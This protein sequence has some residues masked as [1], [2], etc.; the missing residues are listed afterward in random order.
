[1]WELLK[2]FAHHRPTPRTITAAVRFK[3]FEKI[4]AGAK[5]IQDS[6]YKHLDLKPSNILLRVRP[7]GSWN[8]ID[9]VITDFGI[10][11]QTNKQTGNAGTP[12]FASP[13]QLIGP[14]DRKSDNYSFGRLMTMIFAEWQTA[15]NILF[16]PVTDAEKP[17]ILSNLHFYHQPVYVVITQLLQ[18]STLW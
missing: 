5:Y 14:G 6:G 2:I 10:G 4:F 9:C 11:G 15:W 1:M 16:Q 12:A 13:E 8:E 3:M 17:N 7:D 18:V